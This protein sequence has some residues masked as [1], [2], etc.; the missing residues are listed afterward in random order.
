[1]EKTSLAPPL[2]HLGPT[3]Q[4]TSRVNFEGDREWLHPGELL[5]G[6][7]LA[8]S[9]RL[10][11]AICNS[12]LDREEDLILQLCVSEDL[13]LT[14]LAYFHQMKAIHSEM[15]CI[16]HFALR[17]PQEKLREKCPQAAWIHSL[18]GSTPEYEATARK[19][20]NKKKLNIFIL[21]FFNRGFLANK[22]HE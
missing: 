8:F 1:V 4:K 5:E 10:V 3:H 9:P 18:K 16:E 20:F 19:V 7:A 12:R 14:P 13:F 17:Y 22:N 15:F 21:F 2:A 11:E 6:G